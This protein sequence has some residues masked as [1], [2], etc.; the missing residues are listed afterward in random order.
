[1]KNKKSIFEYI[2]LTILFILALPFVL[3]IY[4]VFFIIYIIIFPFENPKYK[5]SNYYKDLKESY[6]LLITR[7]KHFKLYNE[8][9][10]EKELVLLNE[11]NLYC[12]TEFVLIPVI[13]NIMYDNLNSSWTLSS[14]SLNSYLEKFEIN[15]ERIVLINR[16]LF[17]NNND[18]KLASK[19]KGFIIFER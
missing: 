17:I 15:K 14:E 7:K 2:I 16:N 8:I 4:T 11:T 10:K 6:Y 3:A 5:K 9:T 18:Y 1:M 12:N 19:D 13:E